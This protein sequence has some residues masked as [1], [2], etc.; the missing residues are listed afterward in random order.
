MS[1]RTR[2]LNPLSVANV[3]CHLINGSYCGKLNATLPKCI[4]SDLLAY[5]TRPSGDVTKK[6]IG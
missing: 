1:S 6:V 5:F 3:L 4:V 2:S